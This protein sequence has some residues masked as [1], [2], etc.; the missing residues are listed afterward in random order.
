MPVPW[1]D[2]AWQ[3]GSQQNMMNHLPVEITVD[4][5]GGFTLDM[6]GASPPGPHAFNCSEGAMEGGMWVSLTQCLLHDGKVNDGSYFAVD[7]H[8]PEGSVANPQDPGLSYHTSWGTI[9]PTYNAVWKCLSRG[10]FARGFREEVVTG[11]AETADAV[12]GGGRLMDELSDPIPDAVGTYFP[13]GPFDVSCQG[14]GASAVRDGLDWGY[15]MWNPEADLGDVEEWEQTQWGLIQLSRRVKPNTAGPGKYRGG[16]GWE[17]IHTV[18]GSEDVSL[19]I[20]A[21]RDVTWTTSG[22]SGGYPGATQYCVRAHKTDLAERIQQGEPYPLGDRR[23][24]EA[25]FEENIEGDI[26]RTHRGTFWPE[27]FDNF[28][29]LHYKMGGGPGWGDPLERPPAKLESDVE[30]DIY[31]PDVVERVYGVV[32]DYDEANREFTVDEEATETKR[33][34]IRRRRAEES[35]SYDE[36]YETERERVTEGDWSEAIQWMY[37]GVFEQSESWAGVFREF[38]NLDEDYVPEQKDG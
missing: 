17:G 33:E 6:T 15:A 28:D 14:L 19:Y 9:M 7:T 22:M 26:I 1:K 16:S 12:Q 11:Y 5:D 20:A 10:F 3:P 4:A 2:E 18:L 27:G 23:P 32:G 36:F 25:S 13:V 35:V 8:Y 30:G 29:L 31:T 38:W 34:E 24:G 21:M 37:E